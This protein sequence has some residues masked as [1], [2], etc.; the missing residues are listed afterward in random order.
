MDLR[1]KTIETRIGYDFRD[2]NLLIRA[3]TH[4]SFA[5]EQKHHRLSNNER[6]E[7]LGD[8]VLSIIISEHLYNEHMSLEEGQLTKIR[9]RIVCE[10]SLSEAAKRI[11]IGKA[12]RFGKGEEMTGGRQRAS[13][14]SDAFEALIA[15]LYLDGGIDVAKDFVLTQMQDIIESARQ[16]HIFTDYKTQLQ[17][18]IQ[19]DKDNK[20]KY[21]IYKEEGP[22]HSKMFFTHV[23]LNEEIIGT[24]SGRS[25]K[26]AEQEA[27]KEGLHRLKQ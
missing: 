7:F 3:L 2:K 26:E 23:K 27:A 16:G 4:S 1:V 8:S 17:E 19:A 13:I 18:V 25:K 15:A 11:D 14:L 24:G 12:M 10:A 20:I 6:L 22:D 9:A 5:N 21:E